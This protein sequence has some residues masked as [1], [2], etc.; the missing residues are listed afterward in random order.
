M[1]QR[2]GLTLL[3]EQ[4]LLRSMV[5]LQILSTRFVPTMMMKN[6]NLFL[7]TL[8]LLQML[9]QVLVLEHVKL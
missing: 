8:L 2:K 5:S 4:I 7:R 9:Y 3:S 6:Q 1:L